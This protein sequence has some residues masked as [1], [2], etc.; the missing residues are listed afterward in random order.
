MSEM[1]IKN[2]FTLLA[3]RVTPIANGGTGAT[4]GAGAFNNLFTRIDGT[5]SVTVA[6]NSV[7]NTIIPF[8]TGLSIDNF[9]GLCDFYMSGTG[10]YQIYLWEWYA[11]SSGVNIYVANRHASTTYTIN[12]GYGL[13]FHK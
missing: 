7:K 4:T 6:P 10:I 12:I 8:P 1:R 13:L 5:K 9:I 3:N 2:L 11:D